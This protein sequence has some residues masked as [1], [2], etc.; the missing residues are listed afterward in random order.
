[1]LVIG[2]VIVVIALIWLIAFKG[3]GG[4]PDLP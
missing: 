3:V 2:G 4:G 1:L